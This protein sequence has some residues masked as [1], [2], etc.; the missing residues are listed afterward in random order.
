MRT[1]LLIPGTL[2]LTLSGGCI[3]LS[4]IDIKIVRSDDTA[5]LDDTGQP[6]SGDTGDTGDTT[7]TADTTETDTGE[8]EDTWQPGPPLG[9]D[10]LIYEGDGALPV[11]SGPYLIDGID[12]L[13]ASYQALGATVDESATLPDDLQPYRLIFW[14]LPGTT[15]A[16]GYTVPDATTDALLTWF[17]SGGRLLLAG[18]VDGS[19][20]AYSL[21][22][23]NLTIDDVLGRLNVDIR[24]S[25][26]VNN[27]LACSG[28]STHALMAGGATLDGYA[29]N[30]VQLEAPAEWLICD[31]VGVQVVR[32]GEVVV[33][34]DVNPFSDHPEAAPQ[35]VEN[36]YTVPPPECQ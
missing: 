27:N 17:A 31:G 36:L 28:A 29:G 7:E 16:E 30:D 24:L 15:E 32:C 11:N 9:I 26:T 19:L 2:G 20:D 21:T 33:S 3:D 6:D 10:V 18:D 1:A 22:Q 14:Y 34:G 8:V 25:A 23:G 13:I 5:A 12:A 35:L 4:A